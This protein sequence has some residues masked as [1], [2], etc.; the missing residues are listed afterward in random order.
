MTE[1]V[2]RENPYRPYGALPPKGGSKGRG[3][4]L[5]GWGIKCGG[6]SHIMGMKK[7]KADPL[8]KA[9]EERETCFPQAGREEF[10]P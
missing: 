4:V 10:R 6:I 5:G 9:K 8:G 2:L 3:R 7:I 1:G